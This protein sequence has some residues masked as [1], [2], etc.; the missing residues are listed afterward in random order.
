MA[1]IKG[2]IDDAGV[3]VVLSSPVVFKSHSTT[4]VDLGPIYTPKID[5]MAYLVERTSAAK[6]GLFVHSCPIDA[7]YKGSVHA[8][9]YNSS[10]HKICYDAGSAFCQLVVVPIETIRDIKCKKIGKRS[11]S[12]AGGT[13]STKD[14]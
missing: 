3:D 5:T 11:T 14:K 2:Y 12:W 6:K 9:V 13:D 4:V 10:N 8:I 7:N 1:L